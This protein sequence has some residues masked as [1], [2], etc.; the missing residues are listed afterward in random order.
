MNSLSAVQDM[1]TFVHVRVQGCPVLAF[2][3]CQESLGRRWIWERIFP[4]RMRELFRIGQCGNQ[5]YRNPIERQTQLLEE[6]IYVVSQQY[7][8]K[9]IIA[10]KGADISSNVS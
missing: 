10:T 2:P 9:I 4:E 1:A 5:S 7:F 8:W 3:I 6:H